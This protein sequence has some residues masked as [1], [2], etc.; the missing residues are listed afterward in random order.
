VHS[1][2][3]YGKETLLIAAHISVLNETFVSLLA[4]A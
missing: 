4:V 1:N 2:R 3:G